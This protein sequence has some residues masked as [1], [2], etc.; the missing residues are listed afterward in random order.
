MIKRRPVVV[1]SPR[2]RN[3]D[4]LCTVVP[5]ST[6]EPKPVAAYHFKLHVSPPLPKP[7]DEPVKWVKADMVYTVGFHRLYLPL[8]K[9]DGNGKRVYDV[10]VIEKSDLLKIQQCVLYGLGMANLTEYL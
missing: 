4:G 7:Y 8:D 1:L 3:R 2:L 9:K 6:T 5:L 10:R